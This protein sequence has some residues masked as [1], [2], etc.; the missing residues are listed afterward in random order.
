MEALKRLELT[1][2]GLEAERE[3]VRVFLKESSLEHSF[4]AFKG[5]YRA[6]LE[7]KRLAEEKKAKMEAANN[8]KEE[9]EPKEQKLYE[10]I[11]T[12]GV[13]VITDCG[14]NET[15]DYKQDD[16]EKAFCEDMDR[17]MEE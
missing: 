3:L 10:I 9:S 8:V 7:K 1:I 5:E 12:D 15:P 2:V 6:R 11:T 14:V 13:E 4:K 16:E 17:S